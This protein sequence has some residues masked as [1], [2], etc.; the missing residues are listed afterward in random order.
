MTDDGELRL[1]RL[2]AKG[3]E[4]SPP[5]R[6]TDA[7][8]VKRLE[9]DGIGRPSTYASIITTIERRGYI[10]RQGKALVPTFTETRVDA[11]RFYD[12]E[13]WATLCRV[14]DEVDP[15]RVFVANHPL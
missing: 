8:L 14:R 11:S 12:G 13:D 15:D 10:W 2:E 3:H 5:A 4:T 1:E 9:E 7:S 6:Y